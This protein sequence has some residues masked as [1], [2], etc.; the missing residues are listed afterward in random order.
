[1]IPRDH[2]SIVI[3]GHSGGEITFVL[4]PGQ[5]NKIQRQRNRTYGN[6]ITNKSCFKKLGTLLF[7]KSE[8]DGV[9]HSLL[10]FQI[11]H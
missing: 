11:A 9:C 8:S 1:M 2:F 4:F 5:L 6:G 7:A 10:Y 3:N